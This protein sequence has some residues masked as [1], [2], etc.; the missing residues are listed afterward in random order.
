MLSNIGPQVEGFI[1]E[2][3][4]IDLN[5]QTQFIIL[6]LANFESRPDFHN[7][8]WSKSRWNNKKWVM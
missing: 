5:R 3:I 8:T 2:T 6:S 7:V 1:S 4:F